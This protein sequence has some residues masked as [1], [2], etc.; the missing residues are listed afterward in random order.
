MIVIK[1]YGTGVNGN[2]YARNFCAAHVDNSVGTAGIK[3]AIEKVRN[4][5]NIEG[6]HQVNLEIT[7]SAEEYS[8]L[9][10]ESKKEGHLEAWDLARRI[11]ADCP[12]SYTID[13]VREIFGREIVGKNTWNILKLPLEFVMAK[14]K[15]Y[16]EEKKN[17]L[18]IG[19]EVV[20]DLHDGHIWKGIVM[21]C[22]SAKPVCV[23]CASDNKIRY[24]AF[25]CVSK[26]GKHFDELVKLL[27]KMKE[28]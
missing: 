4:D 2:E 26:T 24:F 18:Q 7:L 13:E 3:A 10:E 11:A 14:D 23:L 9:I 22:T 21:E 25:E 20:V 12:V 8:N 1:G 27:S 5:M 28:E 15:K 6:T 19:D 16:Q 17:A